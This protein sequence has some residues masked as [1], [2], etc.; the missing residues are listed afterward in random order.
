MAP[1]QKIQGIPIKP[2]E[3]R[4]HFCLIFLVSGAGLFATLKLDSTIQQWNAQ[5]EGNRTHESD[6]AAIEKRAEIAQAAIDIK[7]NRYDSGSLGNYICDPDKTPSFTTRPYVDDAYLEVSDQNDRIIGYLEY[8][9]F[10]FQ[11]QNCN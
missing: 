4:I 2:L 3:Y 7:V 6:I 9:R 10:T 5:R 11:P 8:G 1:L